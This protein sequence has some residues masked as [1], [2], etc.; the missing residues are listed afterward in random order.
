MTVYLLYQRVQL[1][2]AGRFGAV[3]AVTGMRIST[4]LT[5]IRLRYR[6]R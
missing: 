5:H 3:H 1:R 2:L 6:S 4:R